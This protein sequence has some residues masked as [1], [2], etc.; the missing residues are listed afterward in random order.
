M[1]QQPW[2]AVTRSQSPQRDELRNALILILPICTLPISM[3]SLLLSIYSV[4]IARKYACWHMASVGSLGILLGMAWTSYCSPRNQSP[5]LPQTTSVQTTTDKQPLP[6]SDTDTD[7]DDDDN[8]ERVHK[9]VL[10]VRTDL[11]MGKGKIAAQCC[12]AAVAAVLSAQQSAPQALRKWEKYGAA[13]V[14]LKCASEQDLLDLY[15]RAR[16]KDLIAELIED[17]GRTQIE[18][19]SRTVLAIGPGILELI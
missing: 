3:D 16:S 12:H 17:A 14:A 9:M 15:S 2:C 19:G 7:S 8:G 18:A 5:P 10:C 1:A 4:L 13:K 6:D 11:G